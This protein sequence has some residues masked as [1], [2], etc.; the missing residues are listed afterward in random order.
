MC[1][2][3]LDIHIYVLG[4]FLS[5]ESHRGDYVQRGERIDMTYRELDIE[6]VIDSEMKQRKGRTA[7]SGKHFQRP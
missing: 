5:I 6:E 4:N 7:I 2:Q 3:I 1:L